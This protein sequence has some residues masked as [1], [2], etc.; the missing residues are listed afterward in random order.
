MRLY[1]KTMGRQMAAYVRDYMSEGT[2]ILVTGEAGKQYVPLTKNKL[3][4]S[5]DVIVDEAPTS[6]NMQERTWAVLETLIPQ[7]LSAGMKLP[8]EILDYAPLPADL[9]EQWKKA[10]QPDPQSMQIQQA[11]VKATLDK[12]VAEVTKLQAGA[13]LDQAKAQEIMA[14]L[15]KPGDNGQQAQMELLKAQVDAQVQS[16]IAEFKSNR[17]AETKL[18]M[19]QM[20]IDSAERIAAMQAQIEVTLE[21]NRLATDATIEQSRQRQDSSTKLTLA[22]IA[23]GKTEEEVEAEDAQKEDQESAIDL[24]TEAISELKAAVEEIKSKP[25]KPRKFKV[26]RDK[27]GEMTGVEEEL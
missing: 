27:Q 17:E 12:L 16:K 9:Q 18:M 15:G 1:Y 11:S 13:Q 3:A 24:V 20:D 5:Y 2:L 14:E 6:V 8:N 23:K 10:L 25:Q 21:R 7:M 26:K 4:Q 19:K 22:A